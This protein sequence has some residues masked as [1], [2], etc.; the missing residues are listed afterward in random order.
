MIS[1]KV[2][3]GG[4]AA[5]RDDVTHSKCLQTHKATPCAKINQLKWNVVAIGL[6][7]IEH[8]YIMMRLTDIA[9][10]WRHV[11]DI[12]GPHK[13]IDHIRDVENRGAYEQGY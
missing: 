6:S 4:A 13:A 1:N 5:L 8:Q 3:P 10:D 11:P 12:L 2:R 9:P 7:T